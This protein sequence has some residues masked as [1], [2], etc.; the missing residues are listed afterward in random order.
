M[1]AVFTS[2]M[3]AWQKLGYYVL[4]TRAR[5]YRY[6]VDSNPVSDAAMNSYYKVVHA[7]TA[8]SRTRVCVSCVHL[9]LVDMTIYLYTAMHTD[10]YIHGCVRDVYI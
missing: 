6:I 7:R 8:K 4:N 3:K 1:Q 5:G 9:H 2:H 10:G